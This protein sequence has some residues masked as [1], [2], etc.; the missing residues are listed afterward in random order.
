MN[1][2]KAINTKAARV[3][4]ATE[5]TSSGFSGPACRSC[6]IFRSAA[7]CFFARLGSG[8]RRRHRRTL[9]AGRARSVRLPHRLL[10]AGAGAGSAE[11]RARLDSQC[12][13]AQKDWR[14]ID[15]IFP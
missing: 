5:T 10:L 14:K 8:P 9:S 1:H 15:L 6:R 4:R 11:S 3:E 12:A 13:A 7:R 2:L